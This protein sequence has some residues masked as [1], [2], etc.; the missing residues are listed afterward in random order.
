MHKKIIGILTSNFFPKQFKTNAPSIKQDEANKKIK[1]KNFKK[2]KNFGIIDAL[3]FYLLKKVRI[4]KYQA[5][6]YNL[7]F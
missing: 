2:A 1:N 7:F 6:S 5:T 3:P 4:Q